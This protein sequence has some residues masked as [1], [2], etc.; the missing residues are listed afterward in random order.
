MSAFV[1]A[2]IS[3]R[4]K[5]GELPCGLCS[6]MLSQSGAQNTFTTR[7]SPS[8]YSR[9]PCRSRSKLVSFLAF[10]HCKPRPSVSGANRTWTSVEFVPVCCFL[11]ANKS[12]LSAKT[13]AKSSGYFESR[14][15]MKREL[16]VFQGGRENVDFCSVRSG[17]P[18]LDDKQT[19]FGANAKSKSSGATS[20]AVP[21]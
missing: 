12:R 7:M 6:A 17:I 2:L 13:N 20:R 15:G 9:T 21:V 5:P 19:R 8:L 14:A 1:P 10:G 4:R 16:F 11:M 18:L 3:A